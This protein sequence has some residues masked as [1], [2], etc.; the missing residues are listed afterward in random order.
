MRDMLDDDE[1][2]DDVAFAAAA[3]AARRRASRRATTLV[4][5]WVNFLF[6]G[7]EIVVVALFVSIG[8]HISDGR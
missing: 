7:A 6:G 8:S 2:D 1:D 4:G 5:V 3:A